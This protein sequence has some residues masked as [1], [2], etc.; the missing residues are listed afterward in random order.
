MESYTHIYQK[1]SLSGLHGESRDPASPL[2][3][4]PVPVEGRGLNETIEEPGQQAPH[5]YEPI[6]DRIQTIA[7]E[8]P[9]HDPATYHTTSEVTKAAAGLWAPQVDPEETHYESDTEY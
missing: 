6:S 2:N 9:E 1:L 7:Y 8:I 5:Y 3:K 4:G